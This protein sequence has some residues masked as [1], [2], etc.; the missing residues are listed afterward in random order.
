MN[1]NF[2]SSLGFVL[3]HECAYA[4]GHE[5]DL[6]YVVC[7]DVPGDTGG[8]TKFG[9][10]AASH[11][12]IDIRGL[13]FELASAIYHDGEW[14]E[15]RCDALP[16]GVDTVVFDCAVNNGAAVSAI[17]LQRAVIA[18]GYGIVVDGKIGPQTV[19]AATLAN[20]PDLKGRLLQLR[21]QRYTD[22]VLHNP[23]DAKFLQGWLNRVDD[24][25]R[26]LFA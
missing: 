4:P 22:I 21:R 11:P 7:E 26:F 3:R 9:I 10:D 15:C 5:G 24:L 8:L 19:R 1:D 2:A 12:G 6:N 25:E 20:G 13:T 17:L 14:T 18:C 16:S 23:A